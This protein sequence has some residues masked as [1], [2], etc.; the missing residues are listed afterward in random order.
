MDYSCG[1]QTSNGTLDAGFAK[2][3][4][5]HQRSNLT[6]NMF[7]FKSSFLPKLLFRY[8]LVDYLTNTGIYEFV[9]IGGNPGEVPSLRT[10]R[11]TFDDITWI[12]VII[13][14]VSVTL[15]LF[16]IDLIWNWVNKYKTTKMTIR[17]H[18]HHGG[19]VE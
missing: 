18:G 12:L 5:L 15:M 17:K 9:L 8:Q 14:D 13:S 7:H 11:L 1:F 4:H 19:H 2:L 10:I 3:S 16:S 6:K